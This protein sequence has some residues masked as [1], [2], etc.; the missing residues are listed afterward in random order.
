MDNANVTYVTQK[1][2]NEKSIHQKVYGVDVI[3]TSKIQS[4]R[5]HKLSESERLKILANLIID[6]I[7]LKYK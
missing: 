6:N 3:T 4:P 1:I 2:K 5:L 7:I